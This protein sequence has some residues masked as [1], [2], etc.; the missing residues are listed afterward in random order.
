MSTRLAALLLIAVSA[1]AQLTPGP[2]WLRR[3]IAIAPTLAA[4]EYAP[5]EPSVLYESGCLIV[6]SPCW[7]MWY[8]G[9]TNAQFYAESTDGLSFTKWPSA[10]VTGYLRSSIVHTGGTYYMF[11]AKQSGLGSADLALLTSPDGVTWTLSQVSVLPKGVAGQWDDIDISNST[12]RI[13]GDG[14]WQM[15]YEAQGTGNPSGSCGLATA[16][17][18]TGPWTK[19]AG[20]PIAANCGG[21]WFCVSQAGNYYFWGHSDIYPTEGRF[22]QSDSSGTFLSAYSR[23]FT[24]AAMPRGDDEQNADI[25]MTQVADPSVVEVGGKTYLYYSSLQNQSPTADAPDWI[26]VAVYNGTIEQVIQTTQGAFSVL[27]H[28]AELH[29]V[30]VQ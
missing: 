12:E 7:K 20:N 30:S 10:V 6:T 1:F 9:W 19:Y 22:W 26:R 18:P 17:G 27:V 8:G 4:E 16:P 2:T 11:A 15:I 24:T 28:G 13:A 3:G 21:P 25:A 29:G 14:T 5:G 23:P